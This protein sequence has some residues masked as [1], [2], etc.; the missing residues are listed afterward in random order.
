MAVEQIS[1]QSH[2]EGCLGALFT[3]EV[4]LTRIR[5]KFWGLTEESH[6][7]IALTMERRVVSRVEMGAIVCRKRLRR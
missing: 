1:N 5:N 2:K 6:L 3:T 7:L 4:P